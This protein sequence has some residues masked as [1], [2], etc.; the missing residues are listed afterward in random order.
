[1]ILH[2]ARTLLGWLR[3]RA[4]RV[5]RV[6]LAAM[7][8]GLLVRVWSFGA[9]PPGLNQDE[10]STAYDA[11]ALIHHGIDRHGYWLPVVLVSWGSGM[12]ALAA[13]VA[14]PFIGL[15]G[16]SVWSA[17]LPFLLAGMAALP[18]FFVLLRDTTDRQ[19]ARIGVVLLSLCP[20]H[21][22]I[23]RW[24]LDSNL[25]PF[26]FLGATLLLQRSTKRPRLLVAAAFVYGLALYAYGTAYVVVPTFIGL[27]LVYGVRHRLWPLR[28]MILSAAL[29]VVVATPIG[30]YVAVNSFGWNSIRTPFFS[31][32]HLSGLPRFRTMGNFNVFSLEFA[33]QAW[34][35][36]GTAAEMFRVQDDGLIWN[37]I[38]GYGILYA[39]SPFLALAGLALLVGK[40]LSRDYQPSFALIAWSLASLILMAFVAA[41]INRANI[42]MFPFVYCVAV[43]VS[44]LCRQRVL[45]VLMCILV[46][47]SFIG[48][49]GNY[50]GPYRKAAAEPFFASFGESIRYAATQSDSEVCVTDKVNMPYIFVLFYNQEDPRMFRQTAHF[51]NPGSEFETVSSF[52]RYK[53]GLGSCA[54]SAAVIVST[55]A[56]TA[57]LRLDGYTVKDFE[58]YS[59]VVRR[60]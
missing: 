13:Y 12:Y 27:A 44:Y 19:T 39:F 24:G 35:N 8:V 11:Y 43:A 52:G 3:T 58:R 26:V 10:A 31:I 15:F 37:A 55:H 18:I 16:L 4:G 41:N 40:N 20:W 22:M 46:G 29:F 28:A 54:N 36:L 56:E 34:A 7:A 42:A 6:L 17:R 14:A 60:E 1:M 50:F 49:V 51:T 5:D 53:F 33:R 48:F 2:S 23:S 21:I 47:A 9:L 57:D 59:V 30:I 45:A 32:P 38:P 25:F